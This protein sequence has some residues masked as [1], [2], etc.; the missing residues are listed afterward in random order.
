MKPPSHLI[1]EEKKQFKKIS[2]NLIEIG[3]M[4]NSDCNSLATY[5]KAY[6]RYVKVALK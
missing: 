6:S 2:K 3:I 4:G 5:I 1:K